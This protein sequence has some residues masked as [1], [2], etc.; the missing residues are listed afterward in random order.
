MITNNAAHY[1]NR[2]DTLNAQMIS[3]VDEIG[4]LEKGGVGQSSNAARAKEKWQLTRP[5][6]MDPA[7]LFGK[8]DEWMKWKEE[9]EDYVDAVQ[10]GLKDVLG[11]A[12]SLKSQ[13]LERTQKDLVQ[14]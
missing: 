7:F 10:M 9:M 8:G 4:Q 1:S 11:R 13:L 6:D 12:A 5:K 2:Q 3:L 14:E